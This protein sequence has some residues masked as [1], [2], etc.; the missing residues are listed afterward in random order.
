MKKVLKLNMSDQT[1]VTSDPFSLFSDKELLDLKWMV[2]EVKIF[3][4][5]TDPNTLY[6]AGTF[7]KVAQGR[8]LIGADSSHTLGSTGGSET[9]SHGSGSI[10]ALVTD[11]GGVLKFRQSNSTIDWESNI[12]ITDIT[13]EDSN[14]HHSWGMETNGD[15]GSASSMQ[16]YLVVNYWKRLT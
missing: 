12:Q 4:D 11:S 13:V 7:E 16:P 9:H 2:S 6:P 5:G 3:T 8:T 10:R 14:S 15:T 1:A